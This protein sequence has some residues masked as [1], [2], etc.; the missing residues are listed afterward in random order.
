[1]G[2]VPTCG[3]SAAVFSGGTRTIVHQPFGKAGETG[4]ESF[5]WPVWRRDPAHLPTLFRTKGGD[6]SMSST[7]T[8]ATRVRMRPV[9]VS[10]MNTPNP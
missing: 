9:T 1:M 7:L 10:T 4:P 5:S 8:L 3:P 6:Q 2:L